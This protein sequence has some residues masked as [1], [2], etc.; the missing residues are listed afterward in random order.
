MQKTKKA[1]RLLGTLVLLALLALTML[2]TESAVDHGQ[3][4]IAGTGTSETLSDEDSA[5]RAIARNFDP[6]RSPGAFPADYQCVDQTKRLISSWK[7]QINV[8]PTTKGSDVDV[9]F[10]L[11]TANPG[12]L[13]DCLRSPGFIGD[14]EFIRNH[15]GRIRVMP[16][17]KDLDVVPSAI[18]VIA[19]A[20]SDSATVTATGRTTVPSGTL[21]IQILAAYGPKNGMLLGEIIVS[22]TNASIT[23]AEGATIRRQDATNVEFTLVPPGT[24]ISLTLFPQIEQEGTIA[25]PEDTWNRI[26][27]IPLVGLTPWLAFL[28]IT[29]KNTTTAPQTMRKL[30]GW[31]ILPVAS[32]SLFTY[33]L[34]YDQT[35]SILTIL[36]VSIPAALLLTFTRMDL[37]RTRPLTIILGA[38]CAIAALALVGIYPDGTKVRYLDLALFAALGVATAALLPVLGDWRRGLLFGAACLTGVVALRSIVFPFSYLSPIGLAPWAIVTYVVVRRWHGGRALA[39]TCAALTLLCMSPVQLALANWSSLTLD[40]LNFSRDLSYASSIAR[41]MLEASKLVLFAYLARRLWLARDRPGELDNTILKAAAI[42]CVLVVAR[43]SDTWY[44]YAGLA[45]AAYLTVA[46]MVLIQNDRNSVRL[47][48]VT[49]SAHARLLRLDARRRSMLDYATTHHRTA[50]A[51]VA[52]HEVTPE[53]AMATQRTLDSGAG[54]FRPRD[55]AGVMLLRAA[56]G[57]AGGNPPGRNALFGAL[58]G[59]LISLPFAVYEA[60]PLIRSILG[61]VEQVRVGAPLLMAIEGAQHFRWTVYAALFGYFYPAIRCAT[62]TTKAM[63]L[64]AVVLPAELIAI[65]FTTPMSTFLPA[66]AIKTGFALFFCLSLGL[67]WEWWLARAASVRWGRIR[68]FTRLKSFLVPVSTIVIAGVTALATGFASVAVQELL[69]PPPAKPVQQPTSSVST[70]PSTPPPPAK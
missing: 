53:D 52:A 37:T 34:P 67:T 16:W 43:D 21:S 23:G 12:I 58:A 51:K 14:V 9:K 60:L 69:Q 63:A 44:R 49:P 41:S 5:Q 59:A 22:A 57:S 6:V 35:E 65:D 19:E 45:V 61:E 33:Y 25:K 36:F 48:S 8:N 42:G 7:T 56:Q 66:A 24:E 70:S 68:D 15:F 47:A 17:G 40:V 20:G 31:L 1:L 10:T 30:F 38:I 32:T 13:T 26:L 28:L 46:L 62:P 54:L 39:A 11:E 55:S 2:A 18:S 3:S 64:L 50:R 4:W 27:L 29:R